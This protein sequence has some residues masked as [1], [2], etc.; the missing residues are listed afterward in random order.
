MFLRFA[1]FIEGYEKYGSRWAGEDL[2]TMLHF[3]YQ[4]LSDAE[5]SIKRFVPFYTWT[6]NNVPLQ[7]RAA[8]T[9]QDK[10]RK[11][12][13]A[14]ENIKDAFGVN[15]EQS[16]LDEVLP[17]YM[18]I[19]GGFASAFTFGGNHLAF[20]PKTP[21]QDVDQFLQTNYIF[22]IPVPMPR[23]KTLAGAL[24]PGVAPLEF[25]SGRSFDTGQEFDTLEER[26][27][28]GLR[29]LVPYYGTAQRIGEAATVPFT[30]AGADLSGLPIL[31]QQKGM[32]SLINFLAGSPYG[33]ASLNERQLSYGIRSQTENLNEQLAR[34]AGEAGVDLDWLRKEIRKGTSVQDLRMKIA[35]G[36]GNASMLALNKQ[37]EDVKAPSRDYNQLLKS[38]GAGGYESGY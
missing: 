36:Q 16:W 33:V 13:I 8:F 32:S 38:L 21:M 20:S 12:V 18:D 30:L 25:I 9:Q 4:D 35:M 10:L 28:W 1:A 29:T 37:F 22:G 14:N 17:D 3:D 26:L 19:N 34:L 5:R 27:N 15:E 7:L 2:A 24:G 31:D 6:R 23:L 11:I